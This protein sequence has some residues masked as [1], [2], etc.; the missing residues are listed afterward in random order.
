MGLY[1]RMLSAYI[2]H[3][4]HKTSKKNI[5]FKKC[6]GILLTFKLNHRTCTFNLPKQ[7]V[8]M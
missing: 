6:I 1:T 7:Y 3:S 5:V 2:V 4:S 8:E